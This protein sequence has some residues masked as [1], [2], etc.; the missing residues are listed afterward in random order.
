MRRMHGE[1]NAA[2]K[3]SLVGLERRANHMHD[4]FADPPTDALHSCMWLGVF[5]GR[6][7]SSKSSSMET[8]PLIQRTK[9]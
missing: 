6:D 1:K 2:T 7:P 9:L 5:D 4:R 8:A 3:N